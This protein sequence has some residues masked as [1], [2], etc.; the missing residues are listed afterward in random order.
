MK[1]I[2]VL[3]AVVA[4]S[5]AACGGGSDSQAG[6]TG[7]AAAAA[8]DRNQQIADQYAKVAAKPLAVVCQGLPTL[9][10]AKTKR[11]FAKILGPQVIRSGGDISEVGDLLLARC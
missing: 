9:G 2:A 10:K 11:L 4:L 1:V 5:F 7:T 8:P 3:M 6:S